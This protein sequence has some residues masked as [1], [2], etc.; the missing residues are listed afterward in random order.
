M[1]CGDYHFEKLFCKAYCKTGFGFLCAKKDLESSMCMVYHQVSFVF[2]LPC[3]AL[4]C[5]S[6]ANS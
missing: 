1:L 5:G 3:K 6:S 4:W 2:F